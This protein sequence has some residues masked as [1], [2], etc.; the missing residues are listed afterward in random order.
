MTVELTRNP[1][2]DDALVQRIAEVWTRVTNAG[3]AV[4][5]VAPVTVAEVRRL[6]RVELAPVAEGRDDLVVATRDGA[7]L[8]FGLLVTEPYGTHR[9]VGTIRRLQRDPR[10]AGEGIGAAVLAELERAAAD[11]G[12]TL[13]ALTVRGGS[14]RED[15]Y[16]ACGYRFDA[17]LPDRL[18]IDGVPTAEHHLSKPLPVTDPPP[19]SAPPAAAAAAEAPHTRTARPPH[20]TAARALLPVLPVLRVHP[21]AVL[22]AAAH[23]GDA[24]LDLTSVE[25]VELA[26][27]ARAVVRTG[28]AVAV[29]DGHVGLIHPRSGLAARHGLALVNAPGTVDAGYRGELKVIVIN[30]DP[31][32]P[33]TLE[34][35]V[36]IAQLVIQPVVNLEPVEV[37]DLPASA[38]GADGF[39][40]TGR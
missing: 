36:R 33:I 17:T 38:R 34:A 11:R 37:A 23:P 29:P 25:P 19:A 9:H 24:G 26:P 15:F 10:V 12:L 31:A 8:G 16:T 14:G 20:D 13:L 35:G 3:G 30:L 2:V 18:L 27:G 28:L 7:L 32:H 21:D 1:P 4:G 6:A 40:S 5:L 22:P 39:G